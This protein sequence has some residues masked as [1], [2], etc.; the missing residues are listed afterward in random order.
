[1]LLFLL[2][3]KFWFQTSERYVTKQINQ[4]TQNNNWANCS[5]DPHYKQWHLLSKLGNIEHKNI[6]DLKSVDNF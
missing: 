1:M 4:N 5:L 2:N 3:V 6:T